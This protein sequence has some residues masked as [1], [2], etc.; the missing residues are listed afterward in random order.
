MDGLISDPIDVVTETAS[1]R[2]ST[3]IDEALGSLTR[4]VGRGIID[5]YIDSL[6]GKGYTFNQLV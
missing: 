1:T 3:V 4:Y 2:V 5:D 6:E